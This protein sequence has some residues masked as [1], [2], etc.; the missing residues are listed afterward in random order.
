VKEL[1][2]TSNQS[3]VGKVLEVLVEGEGRKSASPGLRGRT[4]TNK[5]VNFAGGKESI[6]TMVK[7]EITRAGPW[8]LG[9]MPYKVIG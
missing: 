8:S 5:V 1:S 9:G 2:F 4:T 7:V 6:G 3:D